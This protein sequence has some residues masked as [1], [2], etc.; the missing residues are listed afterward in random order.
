MAGSGRTGQWGSGG[1]VRGEDPQGWGM[2]AEGSGFWREGTDKQGEAAELNSLSEGSNL[3][4]LENGGL[5][6]PLSCALVALGIQRLCSLGG[7]KTPVWGF[8]S[9]VEGRKPAQRS[10]AE[11][12]C[13]DAPPPQLQSLGLDIL[14]PSH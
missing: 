12:H 5:S 9:A 10:W 4:K 2:F 8:G 7:Q 13:G 11:V 6:V 14:G 1:E 3:V